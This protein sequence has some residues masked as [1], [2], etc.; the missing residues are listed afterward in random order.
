MSWLI[1]KFTNKTKSVLLKTNKSYIGL[2]KNLKMRIVAHKQVSKNTK[3]PSYNHPFYKAIRKYG[4]ENFDLEILEVGIETIEEANK[5][6]IYWIKKLKSKSPNG[7]NLTNGGGGNFGSSK[8]IREGRTTDKI[9]WCQYCC[10]SK[11]RSKFNKTKGK[12]DGLES[13]CRDCMKIIKNKRIA[14]RRNLG[15]YIK[16]ENK[17]CYDCKINKNI[18][19]FGAN[20]RKPDGKDVRCK[21]CKNAKN[22]S[23]N[24]KL[25]DKSQINLNDNKTCGDCKQVK[26]IN[27][28][29]ITKYKIMSMCKLCCAE[30][31]KQRNINTIN[32]DKI[33]IIS[34]ICTGCDENKLCSEYGICNNKKDGL[35]IKCKECVN[36]NARII[37]HNKKAAKIN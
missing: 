12:S 37:A 24:K 23:Q 28:F 3:Y 16:K 20:T 15:L 25:L 1:Y 34:K 6:E 9:K 19:D 26:T 22:R 17:I 5:K 32:S 7:Y 18:D 36:N 29:F 13:Y 35:M 10:Q 33:I 21:I 14:R 27:D 4:F 8:N 11:D 2:T 30:N 31:Q